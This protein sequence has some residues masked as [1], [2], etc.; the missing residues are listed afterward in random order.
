ME[1]KDTGQIIQNDSP[2]IMKRTTNWWQVI[3]ACLT[4][5]V[6]LTTGLISQSNT[7][8]ELR[9]KVINIET[10]QYDMQISND[11]KFDRLD[12]K[13]DLIQND[14]RQILI[15]LERKQDRVK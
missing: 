12:S 14:T 3:A 6:P 2:D 15:N 8:S 13:I 5:A 11:K 10:K 7:I 9:T 1:R 4:V